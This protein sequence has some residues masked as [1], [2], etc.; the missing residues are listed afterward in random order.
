[1]ARKH[2]RELL[3]LPAVLRCLLGC[4]ILLEG[5]M[6]SFGSV[7]DL[8]PLLYSSLPSAYVRRIWL[9]TTPPH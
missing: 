8:G 3:Y 1:M 9:S 2:T 7:L 5:H 6:R 4:Q